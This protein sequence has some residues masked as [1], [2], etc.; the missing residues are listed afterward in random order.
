[1]PFLYQCFLFYLVL[2]F[3]QNFFVVRSV[4]DITDL[5]STDPKGTAV[6]LE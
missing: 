3:H 4:G 2:G 5:K 6:I 1:M